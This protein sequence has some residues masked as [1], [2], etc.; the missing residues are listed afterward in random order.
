LQN[1]NRGFQIG[2]YKLQNTNR[3]FRIADY[4]LPMSDHLKFAKLKFAI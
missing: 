3:R 4:K 2:E 1:T